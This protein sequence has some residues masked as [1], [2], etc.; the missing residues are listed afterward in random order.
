MSHAATLW[1]NPDASPT[2][3]IRAALVRPTFERLLVLAKAHGL[4]AVQKEWQILVAEDS[5]EARRA[6]VS[7]ERILRHLEQGSHAAP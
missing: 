1:S 4:E 7:V 6:A 2:A 3:L 5:I